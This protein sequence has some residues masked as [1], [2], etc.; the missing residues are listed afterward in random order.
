MGRVYHKHRNKIW[1]FCSRRFVYGTSEPMLK[2]LHPKKTKH[3]AFPPFPSLF[4]CFA[5]LSLIS[6]KPGM[7]ALCGGVIL[8]D[9]VVFLTKIHEKPLSVRF[10][11]IFKSMYLRYFAVCY[12]FSSFMSR[13]YLIWSILFL[14]LWPE[15][16]LYI[17]GMH[18]LAGIT[19]YF[20]RKPNL[21]AVIYLYFFSLDQFSYQLG[22]WKGCLRTL[23]F[24]PVS[25]EI[26]MGREF[27]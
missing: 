26:R 10:I 25:P 17:L 20:I 12:H 27:N 9:F 5:L 4:W 7:F 1:H 19:D 22:V 2:K 6:G 8:V 11:N 15:V 18:L 16:S 21:N 23:N 24:N 13:Y 14:P 3:M